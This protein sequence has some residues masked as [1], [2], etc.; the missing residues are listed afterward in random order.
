M[1]ELKGI[2]KSYSVGDLHQRVLKGINLIF[3]ESEF[4]A[5]LGPSGSGKTTLLNIIGGL[6]HYDSGD[7][8]IN[9]VSTKNFRD[10]DWDAYRNHR[11][12]FVFQSYN[13]IPHQ[14]ILNNVK[15]ALTLSGISKSEGTQRARKALEEV[16][17]KEHINKRP[18]QLSGGQMQRVAIARALVNNPDI[19][20]ADEPTG[21]LDSDTSVQIMNLLKKISQKKLVIV[22]THNPELAD[23]Y[24]TRII[25]LRDGNIINDT[26]PY[27]GKLK[28]DL[29]TEAAAKK[30]HKTRMSFITALNLSMQNLLTKKARTI[31]VS[32]A[33]SIG[34][35]G[36]ALIL[37]VS[38]GF[39]A[40]IDGIERDTLT[41]YPLALMKE[42][43]NIAEILLS[44]TGNGGNGE[45]NDGKIHE[46]QVISSTLGKVTKNDLAS[47][48]DYLNAHYDEVGS[49]IR[50]IENEY[51][52]DPMIYTIDATDEL[53]RLNP[54]NLF[55][56]ILG[57]NSL[58]S[59]Y[60][61]LT[62]AFMQ[63]DLENIKADT[64]VVAGRYPE[65]YNELVIY[66]SNP[67][68]ISDFLTYSL[69]FHDTDKLSDSITKIMGGENVAMNEDPLTLEYDDFLNLDLRLVL[70]A[71][72]YK[73][74]EKYG[75]YED[76]SEDDSF[77]QNI[78]DNKSEKL[79][80]VGIVTPNSNMLGMGSG[81]L[82]LPSLVEH[83]IEESAKT[84]IVQ[85]QLSSPTVDIFSGSKFGEKDNKYAFEFSDL[86]SVDESKISG[87]FKTNLDQNAV[88]AKTQE[89][90]N[91]ISNDI[92][93]NVEPVK[94]PLMNKFREMALGLM[95][96]IAGLE[97]DGTYQISEIETLVSDYIARQDFSELEA[98]YLLPGSVYSEMYSGLLK[99][100]LTTYA[101]AYAKAYE[102]IYGQEIDLETADI[103]AEFLYV[104]H[105]K[106][107]TTYLSVAEV[108]GA[109]ETLSVNITE[110]IMKKE[111]LTEVG[112]L[113]SYLSS[114]FASAFSL[115]QDA[116]L[117]AFKLNF[118]EDELARVVSA[119]FTQ[120][121]ST[122][123]TNLALL[124]YQ[125]LDDP[126]EIAFYFNSFEGKT[127]FMKFLDNYNEMRRSYGQ[128]DKV[129]EYSD[130]TGILMSSVKTIVDA[131]SYVLIAF[132]S[133][134]LIVSSI[135][136]GVITYI[137]VYERTKEI[138]I[139]RAIGASKRNI[140]NI[141][142][143]ET[144]I[145]GF[146]SGLFGIGFSYLAIPVINVVLH[147]FTG[148]IPLSAQLNPDAALIL[149]G[150]SIVL[151]LVG[152]LIPAR[153]ASRKDPVEALRS[154]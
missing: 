131:V 21:A 33:G 78:Y 14:T 107:I 88:T 30:Q 11:I 1:L 73:Y 22:V 25:N 63:Y 152:G 151:T 51:N 92:T 41:S 141:F 54:N 74:N 23:E 60:S 34:I 75:V 96:E 139:L 105:E 19:L 66:L 8:K 118:S 103:P 116:L 98:K 154:E 142:N 145:I 111:I 95:S 13:L 38:T 85:K 67:N 7:L 147:H 27:D 18:S 89:Y 52:V 32:V 45:Q 134:S 90:M 104:S 108:N 153:A 57:S 5:I 39:Q 113:T 6:D 44:V 16:G 82:Y 91:N 81:A 3:R 106:L 70:P 117:S 80:V 100:Y 112:G 2:S 47:F 42:S 50:L 68:Q 31:L 124:G 55:S 150:L 28:T 17:L 79:K 77:M 94:E 48:R 20:L 146:L 49:G 64:H 137:S 65:K 29:D 40:Y 133:I 138:G 126:Q 71:D 4:A 36:I 83:I 148:D 24:A 53:A 99:G 110:I 84:E 56:T 120:K 37:S 143:A 102:Q 97:K 125:A 127:E 140:S 58:M 149:I 132:V 123:S 119:M 144:F 76:M 69:G 128:D 35:I 93:A 114:S 72:T 101:N 10:K 59:S 9:E 136:I 135:M 12:G 62:S 115:D 109:F 121:E 86:V 15:L 26:A 129:I 87:A 122:L 61:S 130:T 43:T 46:N